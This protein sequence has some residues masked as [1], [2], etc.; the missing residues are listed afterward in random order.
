MNKEI[1]TLVGPGAHGKSTYAEE[2]CKE[3]TN[4]IILNADS[5]REELYGDPTIQGDGNVV[6][7]RLFDRYT[8]LLKDDIHDLIVIDNTSL[9]YK[10]RKRYYVLASDVCPM[11]DHTYNYNLVFF[12]PYL[13]RALVWNRNRKRQVPEVVL[14]RQCA[15]YQGPNEIEREKCN[16]ITVI[17]KENK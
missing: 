13:E 2:L 14:T 12:P 4:P 17:H 3:H 9:T 15:Q 16:I 7:G 8:A 11:F 5:I 1:F 10:I 6:F